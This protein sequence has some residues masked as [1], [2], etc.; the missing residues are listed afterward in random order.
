V[1]PGLVLLLSGI[2]V[3]LLASSLMADDRGATIGASSL[4]DTSSAAPGAFVGV[5]PGF[6]LEEVPRVKQSPMRSVLFSAV[7]PGL[8][9]AANGRWAKASAFVVVGSLLVSKILVER[10]R[11]DRYLHLSRRAASEE[12]SLD[13]YDSYSSHYDRRG[14]LVWWAITFWVYNAF[15]AYVD[16]HLFGFSRQ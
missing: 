16:G 4:P 11:A 12:E 5:R 14:Q 3:L 15:D 9:Q 1:R 10:D 6:N 2:A 7:V 13:Y 8:G